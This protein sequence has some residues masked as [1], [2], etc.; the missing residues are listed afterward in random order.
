MPDTAVVMT[1]IT[2]KSALAHVTEWVFD[3]DNTLYPPAVR[4]F[5]QIEEKMRAFMVAELS[6]DAAEANRLRKHYWEIHGT[7]L[8]GLMRVHDIKPDKFL[9]DVHDI[10]FADLQ[11]DPELASL[12]K[13][14]PGRSIVYT[15][16]TKPYAQQVLKARGLGGLFD[17]IYGIEHANYQPKP[18]RAAFDIVFGQDG[19]THKDAAMFEDEVRNL[20]VPKSMGL[21]TIHV[22]PQPAN[23][24]YVDFHTDNL[25][26]FL[27]HISG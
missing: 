16:G 20:E 8:S 26:E 17:E 25:T 18:E 5:D 9:R 15:N 22:A 2:A 13:N 21:R 7:T 1:Q 4:L 3:L 27:R 6:I 14:L 23:E 12:I 24:G 10:S 11:P 19:L